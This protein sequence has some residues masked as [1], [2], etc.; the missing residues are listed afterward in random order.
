MI[1]KD[2]KLIL[3]SRSFAWFV[4]LIATAAVIAVIFG[5]GNSLSPKISLG[6]ADLDRSEYS[7]M[8]ITYFEENVVFSSYISIERGTEPELMRRFADGDI[9]VFLVIPE[10]FA[11]QLITITNVPMKAYISSSDRTKAV[12]YKN[13]LESYARYITAVE[14]NCQALYDIMLTEGFDADYV[15]RENVAV[16]YELIF[17]ALGKDE[18]FDY[19]HIERFAG[20]SLVNYYIYAAM[21]LA[22]LYCGMFSGLSALREKLTNVEMR[23]RALGKRR[24]GRNFTKAFAYFLIC[25]GLMLVMMLA[26]NLLAGFSFPAFAL[27]FVPACV[28]VS[29]LLFTFASGLFSSTGGYIMFSNMLI[30]LVTIVG[31]GI[32]PL[33][34]LPEAIARIAVFTPNYWFIKILL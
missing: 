18:F 31:G 8:L 22:V 25:G 32:I 24:A 30:L 5:R 13:L 11:A 6:I 4:G 20:V 3:H 26:V 21:A 17:T 10:N 34:Y 19:S 7:E 14:V 2:I 9:D 15:D 12:I 33:M 27:V 16:S 29:A 28:F 23:L 1:L